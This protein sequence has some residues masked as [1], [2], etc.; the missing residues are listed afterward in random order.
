MKH[1]IN[2]KDIEAT[3]LKKILKDAKKRKYKRKKLNTLDLDKGA[4]LRGKILI[5]MFEKPS[6]R[7]RLSFYLAIRQLG[8]G[9]ITLRS[10]E[11]HIGRGGESLADTAKILSTYGDGFMLRTDSDKKI[12]EFIL[13]NLTDKKMEKMLFSLKASI[14]EANKYLTQEACFDFIKGHIIFTPMNM[15]KETG[16][17]KK[18]EF[19]QTVLSEDLF[20]HCKTK[21]QKIYF[22]G[23]M[24]NRLLSCSFGWIKQDDRDSYMNKPIDLTGSLLNNLFRNYFN[25][26]VKDTSK[27]IVREIN[28]GSW[29]TTEDYCS[30]VNMTNIYK[31]VKSTTIENGIKRALA[32]GDFGIR[33]TTSNKVGVAQVLNRLTYISSLSHLRRVNTPIDKSGKLIPPRKLHSTSWGFLCPAETPEGGSVGVV[34]NLSYMTNVTIPCNSTSLY[35]YVEPYIYTFEEM[36]VDTLLNGVKMFVNGAWVGNAKDPIQLYYS[37]KE[38]KYKGIINIYSVKS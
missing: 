34:K 26:L 37:L 15:D 10:N 18:M 14:I 7:T 5:Q 3:D 22:L 20:P 19:T 9:T 2:L 36:D 38:K 1:F 30:I 25:K 24:T 23:Y 33:Q 13:L 35:D 4:P 11:L 31:I 12:S 28:N 6:L 17:R 21:E 29:R 16:I 27:Q 8:G 32:T